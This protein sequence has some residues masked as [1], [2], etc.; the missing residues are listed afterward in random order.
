[1]AKTRQQK[2]KTVDQIAT[3]FDNSK[4]VVFA[5][6]QGLS[7]QDAEE[8][9]AKCR[10]ANVGMTVAK[11]SLLEYAV[12]KAGLDDVSPRAFE[13]GVATFFGFE[14]EIAPAQVVDKFGKDHEPINIIGGIFEGHFIAIEKVKELAALP[15]KQELLARVV[16]SINAPVSG[17]VN[18]LAGNLRGLVRVLDAIKASKG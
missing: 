3:D 10:E 7:V 4:S 16:G 14:D 9:R 11:K 17:F 12:K 1:M 8:L 5:N 18:V 6:F 2:E 15:S 13:G